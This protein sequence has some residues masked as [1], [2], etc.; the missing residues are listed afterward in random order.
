MKPL[1]LTAAALALIL[2]AY[3]LVG[4][5]ALFAGII[6]APLTSVFMIFE[7]T[8]DYQIVVPLMVANVLSYT[9]SKR[10]QPEPVYEALLHQDNV[11]LPKATERGVAAGRAARHLMQTDPDFISA[12]STIAEAWQHASANDAVA[13]LVGSP[14]GLVGTVTRDALS[15]AMMAQR[16]AEPVTE[17]VEEAVVH[18]H[19]D[20]SV[21][22][23][24]ERFPQGPG[25][26]PVVSRADARRVEGVIT[27][28]SIVQFLG[29]RGAR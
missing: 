12:E 11:H 15:E 13:F 20:H 1:S 26:L 16:A 19:A 4:M 21:D 18:V 28:G 14:D 24:L 3:A 8:Q 5:G 9:I 7:V 25:L 10:Y 27:I 22:V 6:R 29:R 2:G 17:I 23:V